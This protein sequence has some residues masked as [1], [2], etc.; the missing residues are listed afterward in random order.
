MIKINFGEFNL[1][2]TDSIEKDHILTLK[3]KKL[4]TYSYQNRNHLEEII[5]FIPKSGIKNHLIVHTE[6]DVLFSEFCS[7]F[8]TISAAGGLVVNEFNQIL[9]I[10][11]N[12]KWDLPKGKLEANETIEM[13]AIREVEEE[14]GIKVTSLEHKLLTTYHT[15]ILNKKHILKSNHWFLM[16]S[17]SNYKLTPQTEEGIDNA[18]WVSVE[19][20]DKLMKN[21]YNSIKDVLNSYISQLN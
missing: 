6:L 5:D 19:S 4:L 17:N 21:S 15:Y 16:R 9:F 3:K 11:R 8:N 14:T 20:I 18:Q 1:F 10:F 12:D 13:A 7:F 2:L